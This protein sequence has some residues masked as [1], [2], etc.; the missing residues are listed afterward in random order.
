M[1]YDTQLLEEGKCAE[2][3][4]VQ[5]EDGLTDGRCMEPITDLEVGACDFHADQIRSWHQMSEPEKAQWEL[6]QE[7]GF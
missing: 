6:D 1:S 2:I 5:T 7:D 4:A 3:V